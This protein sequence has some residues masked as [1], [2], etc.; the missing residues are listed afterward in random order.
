[1]CIKYLSRYP[2]PRCVTEK[3][4]IPVTGT[5]ADEQHHSHLHDNN[6]WLWCAISQACKW[7]F[8]KGLSVTSKWIRDILGAKSE[9]P[10]QVHLQSYHIFADQFMGDM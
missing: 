1:V 8:V 3:A 6:N 4:L 10:N 7:I 5:R 2:C 9:L